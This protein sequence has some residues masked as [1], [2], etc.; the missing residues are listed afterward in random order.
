MKIKLF[1]F[2][3]I[4]S[5]SGHIIRYIGNHFFSF[6]T[7]L[8]KKNHFFDG[9]SVRLWKKIR[10]FIVDDLILCSII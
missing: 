9:S 6:I 7:S 8:S 4:V 3:G 5:L 1:V 2:Q 10:K